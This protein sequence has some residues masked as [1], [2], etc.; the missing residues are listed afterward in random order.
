MSIAV[1]QQR[2]K[3]R[4]AK[5]TNAN[6]ANATS[7]GDYVSPN[8]GISFL[9][10]H[11][12]FFSWM[13]LKHS[14]MLTSSWRFYDC[15][16]AVLDDALAI[17]NCTVLGCLLR[18]IEI[19]A[20]RS[21]PQTVR[22]D[23]AAASLTDTIR[24]FYNTPWKVTVMIAAARAV[25]SETRDDDAQLSGLIIL[26]ALPS[27]NDNPPP[28]GNAALPGFARGDRRVK[29]CCGP[30]ADERLQG[31]MGSAAFVLPAEWCSKL[32]LGFGKWLGGT[33]QQTFVLKGARVFLHAR[34]VHLINAPY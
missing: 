32:Q 20:S 2:L 6:Y 22:N 8:E 15:A 28:W 13:F 17:R 11:L 33:A 1:I 9:F 24:F 18:W 14:Q 16:C 7:N 31:T 30:A 26:C 12:E 27:Y 10:L 4:R 3:V 29:A 5:T 34:T 23:S 19:K 21:K 25:Y